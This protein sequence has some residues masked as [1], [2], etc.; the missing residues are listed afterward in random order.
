[1]DTD[2]D[3]A[4]WAVGSGPA[5]WALSLHVLCLTCTLDAICILIL[6]EEEKTRCLFHPT[7]PTKSVVSGHSDTMSVPA[8]VA[9]NNR[10]E[11]NRII[12]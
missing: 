12:E 3:I 11:A 4:Y 6:E 8:S 5:P 7:K 1:M 10:F 2:G 9:T